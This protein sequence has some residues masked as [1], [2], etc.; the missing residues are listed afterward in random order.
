M[1][2]VK[3]WLVVIGAIVMVILTIIYGIDCIRYA[4]KTIRKVKE[5]SESLGRKKNG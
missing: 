5:T 4:N 3:D 2:D 1:I